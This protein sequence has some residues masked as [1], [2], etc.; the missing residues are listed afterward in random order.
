[1][2]EPGQQARLGQEL[3]DRGWVGRQRLLQ[4]M[5][6]AEQLVLG[7]VDRAIAAHVDQ[8]PQPVATAHPHAGRAR[9]AGVSRR[10]QQPRAAVDAVQRLRRGPTAAGGAERRRLLRYTHGT[11]R[12]I[13]T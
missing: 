12:V 10:G 2:I 11:L 7:L 9:R 8:P 3:L 6:R 4:R 1:M 13:G 5:G